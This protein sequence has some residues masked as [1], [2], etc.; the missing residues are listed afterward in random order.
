MGW[1]NAVERAANQQLFLTAWKRGQRVRARVEEMAKTFFQELAN[2]GTNVLAPPE[3]GKY[4]PVWEPLSE[5]WADEK[6]HDAFF[7]DTG[8]FQRA[9]LAKD[10]TT[11]FGR[12]QVFLDWE[13]GSRKIT[14]SNLSIKWQGQ[15]LAGLKIRVIPFP[16]W[17]NGESAEELVAGGTNNYIWWVLGSP[18]GRWERPLLTPF[19]SWWIHGKLRSAMRT[20]TK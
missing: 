12:P 16:K 6:G 2:R 18:R 3:L 19:V 14:A 13:G 20:L 5:E 17:G 8:A 1:A 11:V 10:P 15:K 9:L 4:T 7:Y